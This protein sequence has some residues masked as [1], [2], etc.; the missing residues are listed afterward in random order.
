MAYN[1]NDAFNEAIQGPILYART[2]VRLEFLQNM[3]LI[4]RLLLK[5]GQGN[6]QELIEISRDMLDITLNCWKHR[7][8]FFGMISD[9]EWIVSSNFRPFRWQNL[10]FHALL[11]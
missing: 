10:L 3:F 1:K 9:F 8:R 4:E 11:Y 7:D 2:L 6:M 5:Y